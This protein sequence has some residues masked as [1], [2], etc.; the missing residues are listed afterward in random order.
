M[1]CPILP[2]NPCIPQDRHPSRFSALSVYPSVITSTTKTKQ[3][4]KAS[5]RKALEDRD[6]GI[7]YDSKILT[8]EKYLD[9]WLEPIRDKGRPGTFKLH[10]VDVDTFLTILYVMVDDFCQSRPQKEQHPGPDSSLCPS[11][12]LTLAIFARWARFTSERG[13]YRYASARLIGAFPSLPNR[14]QFNWLVRH[15]PGLIEEIALRLADMM[16]TQRCPYL[17]LNSSA[18]PF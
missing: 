7:A 15:S 8:V 6:K 11:E 10:M 5:V 4:M 13:F 18:T 1:L 12:V 2:A 9:R 17:A 14:S 3:E 16:E